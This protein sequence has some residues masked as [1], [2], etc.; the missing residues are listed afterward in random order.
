MA[1]ISS[2]LQINKSGGSANEDQHTSL[3]GTE[4]AA[5]GRLFIN[6]FLHNMYDEVGISEASSG[7]EEYRHFYY[8]NA[9]AF[10]LSN[11]KL[12][13]LSNTKEKWS[14]VYFAKGT[15]ANGS[16]EQAV[17]NENTAPVGISEDAWISTGE[18]ALGTIPATS[19]ASIWTRR[20]V[21]PGSLIVNNEKVSFRILGDPPGGTGTPTCPAG[22]HYD[23]VAAACVPDAITCPAGQ[24]LENSV[25][26]PDDGGQ[27]GGGGGGSPPT[28]E[29]VRIAVVGDIGCNSQGDD[30]VA[31]V[32]ALPN[33]DIFLAVG[34]LTYTSS[35]SCLVEN[36]NA[37]N[38]KDKTRIVIG[39]H[40]DTEDGSASYRSGA[41]SAFGVPSGGYYSFQ[42]QNVFFIGMDTQRD[43]SAS[44]LQYT[45]V[46]AAL[47]T[48]SASST[49][50]WIIVYYHKPSLTCPSNHSALTDF[51]TTYH[52]LFDTYHVDVIITGHNH[53]MQRSYPVKHNAASPA[54]PIVQSTSPDNIFTNIDGR[55]FIVSGAGGD[56]HYGIDSQPSWCVFAEDSTYG[57][58]FMETENTSTTRSL[59]GNFVSAESGTT[60]E[61]L[62]A[63]I[64]NK[65]V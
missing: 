17:A 61:I 55:V 9:N 21:E 8:V 29:P 25:C 26:V 28:P 44:S 57:I 45:F 11:A 18:I 62:D 59:I 12:Q 65:T 3:G 13:I 42:V 36:L 23:S 7:D 32:A 39:N 48:A 49:V 38:I 54:S 35:V 6:N 2:T 34:D 40:D 16:R 15:A 30:T 51:R 41:L 19:W 56:S 60:I 50:D 5:A 37:G 33:L 47:Q 52:P 46:N 64:L 1:V 31:F 43:Y 53:N 22:E 14:K 24:H 63:F 4:S 58:F 20:K 27:G 10:S